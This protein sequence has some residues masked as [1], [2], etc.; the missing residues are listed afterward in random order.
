MSKEHRS[1]DF[2]PPNARTNSFCL[3]PGESP[4]SADRSW[5]RVVDFSK[6][7]CTSLRAKVVVPEGCSNAALGSLQI[8]HASAYDF[9][10]GTLPAIPGQSTENEPNA[11]EQVQIQC[12]KQHESPH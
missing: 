5:L 2:C 11:L 4:E 7:A 8:C 12:R 3:E 6:D 9:K 1:R 10:K